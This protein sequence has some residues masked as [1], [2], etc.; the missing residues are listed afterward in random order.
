MGNIVPDFHLPNKSPPSNVTAALLGFLAEALDQG[1]PSHSVHKHYHHAQ[2][3]WAFRALRSVMIRHH[4]T[5]A[6]E[7]ELTLALPAPQ[8]RLQWGQQ[9]IRR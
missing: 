7:H 6:E 8:S 5:P 2:Q 3:G 4:G 9:E 1:P